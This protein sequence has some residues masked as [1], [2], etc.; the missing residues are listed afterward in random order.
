MICLPSER[1]LILM[2]SAMVVSFEFDLSAQSRWEG[3]RAVSQT[4]ERLGPL[5]ISRYVLST[6][7]DSRS[8]L[9]SS[10]VD[11]RRL[12]ATFVNFVDFRRFSSNV[13]DCCSRF[14]PIMLWKFPRSC[15]NFSAISCSIIA[16]LLINYDWTSHSYQAARA[17]K[18]W[19]STLVPKLRVNTSPVR[20]PD[21]F[22]EVF[23]YGRLE[24][25]RRIASRVLLSGMQYCLTIYELCPF[26]PPRCL[27]TLC[28]VVPRTVWFCSG[29]WK[30]ENARLLFRVTRAHSTLLITTIISI[31]SRQEGEK[32]YK[33]KSNPVVLYC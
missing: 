15:P 28:L 3:I 17:K 24:W 8:P 12:S 11:S 32:I 27:V 13:V 31:S 29:T 25:N 4:K 2:L 30:L 22:P 23:C 33:L 18:I 9:S 16:V 7:V 10:F 19:K 14:Q 5:V 6:L 20:K 1:K 21:L 26:L